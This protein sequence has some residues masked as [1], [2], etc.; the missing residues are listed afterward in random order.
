[1]TREPTELEQYYLELVNRARAK[2]NA[3]VIR[4]SGQVWGDKGF[5]ATPGLNEGLPAGTL[6]GTAR[7]PLAFDPRL[8]DTADAYTRLLLDTEQFTHSANGTSARSRM[9]AQGYVFV[10]SA[11]S[12]EN[13]A[14]TA[15]T[16]PHPVD[17]AR[18]LQHHDGLFI[19]GDVS[20]RGHR[21]TILE[22]FFR[23]VGIAILADT[24]GQSFFNPGFNDVLSTQNFATSSG[25][26]FVTGVIFNDGN[27]N[28]FYEPG[29][30][31]GALA[32]VVEDL[33]GNPV[34]SGTSF[35]SGGY[36]INLGNRPAGNYLLVARDGSGAGAERFDR[37]AGLP[38]LA[39]AARGAQTALGEYR[40]AN[41]AAETAA[42]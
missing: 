22:P 27:N 21:K 7:P 14:I 37:S 15:S 23:E 41:A 29:E 5:P 26:T 25:R 9:E 17:L 13:L 33:F 42:Q 2:P 40:K 30:S 18:V 20:G 19:D 10:P 28:R 36:S 35:A 4:L 39:K 8:I 31:A 1:M 38:G 24:D 3:E 16:G 6:N 12:G 11:G 32:L 34:A